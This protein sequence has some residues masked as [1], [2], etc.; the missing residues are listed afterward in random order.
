MKRSLLGS[1]DKLPV[2]EERGGGVVLGASDAE[3]PHARSLL[4]AHSRGC[5]ICPP[6]LLETPVAHPE[7]IQHPAHAWAAALLDLSRSNRLIH[8]RIRASSSVQVV[9]EDARDVAALLLADKELGFDPKPDDGSFDTA[10]FEVAAEQLRLQ[11]PLDR[12]RLERVLA[13]LEAGA[14]RLW[15][16][17]RITALH[18]ALGMLEYRA[19]HDDRPH[20]APL[21][22]VPVRLHRSTPNA[23]ASMRW[24]GAPPVFNPVLGLKLRG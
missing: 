13:S 21:L 15:E 16:C 7:P 4:P 11:T 1:G 2:H 10:P 14:A 3:D 9:R 12:P 24:T 17:E 20:R 18:V 8:Y 22:L 5:T 23:E 19:A 6:S